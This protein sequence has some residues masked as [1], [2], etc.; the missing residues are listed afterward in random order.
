[1]ELTTNQ[2]YALIGIALF[3]LTGAFLIYVFADTKGFHRGHRT[4][5]RRGIE[6]TTAKFEPE[7]HEM[8]TRCTSAERLLDA[9]QSEL[10]QHKDWHARFQQ[11]SREAYE[12]Q[13]LLLDD[14][15]VLNDQHARLLCEA[16]DTLRLAANVW[17]PI[18]ATLKADAATSQA[19]QLRDLAGWLRP[20]SQQQEHAA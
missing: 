16:A 2:I 7:L 11:D 4:G 12:A 3:E 18:N 19:K 13:Q 1:M 9:T 17:R 6:S 5:Y 15:Q 20:Q 14:A 8:T 10:R